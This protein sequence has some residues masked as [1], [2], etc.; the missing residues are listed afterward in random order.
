[1][2]VV[3]PKS[4]SKIYI[5]FTVVTVLL[6]AFFLTSNRWM[7]SITYKSK[8]DNYNLQDIHNTN[9]RER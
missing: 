4:S 3:S 8:S 2:K 5:I 6:A 9:L 7:Q 1:M